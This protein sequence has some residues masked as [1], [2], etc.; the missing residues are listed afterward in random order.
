MRHYQL[1]RFEYLKDQFSAEP[2]PHV[3]KLQEETKG[4]TPG[5]PTPT[6]QQGRT[7]KEAPKNLPEV[8]S[9]RIPTRATANSAE[10]RQQVPEMKREFVPKSEHGITM[11]EIAKSTPQQQMPLTLTLDQLE[12]VKEFV[13]NELA[14]MLRPGLAIQVTSLKQTVKKLKRKINK[15]K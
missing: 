9:S 8:S 7:K 13:V 6:K 1:T 10:G 3:P 14:S 5:A 11:T 2:E 12:D 15:A 4:P